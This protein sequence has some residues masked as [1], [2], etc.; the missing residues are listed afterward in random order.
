LKTIP[1]AS[2]FKIKDMSARL[3]EPDPWSDYAKNAVQITKA[4]RGKL[5]L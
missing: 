2:V 5:G 1:S 3:A 4:A